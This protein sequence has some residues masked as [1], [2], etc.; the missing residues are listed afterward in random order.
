[1][2]TRSGIFAAA[3]LSA[4][5]LAAVPAFTPDGRTRCY[6]VTREGA[7]DGK[8][9]RIFHTASY[10]VRAEDGLQNGKPAWVFFRDDLAIEKVRTAQRFVVS[11]ETGSIVYLEKKMTAADGTVLEDTRVSFAH[12]PAPPGR[13]LIHR[14]ML[15]MIGPLL[16]LRPG[17][18]NDLALVFNPEMRP[19]NVSLTVEA[20]EQVKT[21]AGSFMCVKLALEY[22][23][24]DLPSIAK[25]IPS[26]LLSSMLSGYYL[27]VDKAAPH[28]MVR[29]SGKLDGPTAPSVTE[30]MVKQ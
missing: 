30:E 11:R 6:R 23:Q 16:N 3:I 4:C 24:D 17:A 1:M 22:S 26:A 13:K 25:Y 18:R 9:R 29:L 14:D 21:P 5:L 7:D 10:T 27:W 28:A 20:E 19:M 15:P 2:K 8:G 12:L